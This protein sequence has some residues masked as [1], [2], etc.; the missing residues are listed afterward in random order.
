MCRSRGRTF[1]ERNGLNMSDDAQYVPPTE[2]AQ[3]QA[4]GR[5]G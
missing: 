3:S 1:Y 4:V 5:P 2:A